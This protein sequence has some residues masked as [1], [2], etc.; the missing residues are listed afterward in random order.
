MLL[1]FISLL[2]SVFQTRIGKI[3]ISETLANVW[4]P[5]HQNAPSSSTTTAHFSTN[6]IPSDGY[7]GRRLLADTNTTDHC[8]EEG[9]VPLLSLT[10]VHHIHIFIFVLATFHVIVSV[11]IILCGK[12]RLYYW[13]KWEQF[14]IKDGRFID[15][16]DR[17]KLLAKKDGHSSG[18]GNR[19]ATVIRGLRM[20][21]KHFFPSLTKSEYI[22]IRLYGIKGP[23]SEN[24]KYHFEKYVI[25][26]VQKD[27]DKVVGISWYLW[28]F[29]VLFLLLNVAGWNAYFWISFLP[30]ALLLAV[31]AK[32][33]HMVKQQTEEIFKKY[34]SRAG[35]S[36]SKVPTIEFSEKDFWFQNP[37]FFLDLIHIILFQNSFELAFFF[38]I[39][40]QYG[41][42]SCIMGEVGYVIPRLVIGV[43]VL[44]MCCYR[45]LPLYA[46]IKKQLPKKPDREKKEKEM[47]IVTFI[48]YC[49]EKWNARKMPTNSGSTQGGSREGLAAKKQ[50]KVGEIEPEKG[51][52][53]EAQDVTK[54][55]STSKPGEQRLV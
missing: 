3:C 36:G 47:K 10:A 37:D 41:F 21:G 18:E 31:G 28:L 9:K 33:E 45:T 27:F 23:Y 5:C 52:D 1:G 49:I 8:G 20:I 26:G 13:R 19:L 6:P 22:A 43:C 54:P 15:E 35:A 4:L 51:A 38:F 44:I 53:I 2:L 24:P 12:A 46:I 11:A 32:L 14:I 30:L 29:V 34:D 55:A 40:F 7:R 48:W 16:K 42:H 39:L 25:R 17:R 50:T